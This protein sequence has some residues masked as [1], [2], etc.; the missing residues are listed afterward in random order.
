MKSILYKIYISSSKLFEDYK[1]LNSLSRFCYLRKIIIYIFNNF[2]QV[3]I[4]L[5]I[6]PSFEM[7]VYFI[8][9][10]FYYTYTYF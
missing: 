4:N 2:E 3:R 1:C 10:T 8:Y 7:K 5:C 6:R 9:I